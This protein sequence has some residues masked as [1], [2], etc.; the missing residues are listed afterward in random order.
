MAGKS[1][2]ILLYR[3]R[4]ETEFFLVHPGGPFWAAKDLEAWS[5]PKGEYDDEDPQVAALREFKEETGFTVT[6]ELFPLGSTKLKSGK[7][8][9]AF[10]AQQDFDESTLSSNTFSFEWP[11]HSGKTIQVPEV[12]KGSWFNFTEATKKI[13]PAQK[14]F[15]DRLLE[16]VSI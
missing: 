10:G 7:K 1:A 14:V 9:T 15:L 11:P 8:V 4:N 5:I 12:D 3:K 6:A 13:N 16:F 2:G